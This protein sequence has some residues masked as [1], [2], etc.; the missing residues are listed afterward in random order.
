MLCEIKDM[1]TDE[2]YE[3]RVR[4]VPSGIWG[5]IK[6]VWCFRRGTHD[7]E[8]V[9]D[10]WYNGLVTYDDWP[11]DGQ[12]LRDVSPVGLRVATRWC[13]RHTVLKCVRCGFEWERLSSGVKGC[14]AHTH[15]AGQEW[16]VEWHELPW[17]VGTVPVVA[18]GQKNKSTK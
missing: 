17:S 14:G 7:F 12:H 3:N 9:V 8:M 18:F 4:F 11:S 6:C 1:E 10:D 13:T 16:P 15:I 5:T 2:G